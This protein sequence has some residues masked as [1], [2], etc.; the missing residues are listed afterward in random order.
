MI[1]FIVTY[2]IIG[3]H[4][5]RKM[6]ALEYLVREQVWLFESN[7]KDVSLAAMGSSYILI[8]VCR[9]T[10]HVE[11]VEHNEIMTGNSWSHNEA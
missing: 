7:A 2:L 3:T 4:K 9:A 6:H 8:P 10:S 1:M 11:K 5:E